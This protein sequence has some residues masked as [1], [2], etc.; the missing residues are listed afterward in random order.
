MENKSSDTKVQK[1]DF[2]NKS[3]VG[4]IFGRLTV[5]DDTQYRTLLSGE[6]KRVAYCKCECG[7]FKNIDL[8][9]LKKGG[10][11]SC[12]CYN[13]D[14]V[15]KR[16]ITHG[17]K[18]TRFY[19]I[20]CD[21]NKRCN[22]AKSMHYK[23]Y[24]GRGI[25]NDFLSFEHFRDTMLATYKDNL[26]LERIDVNGNYSPSNCTWIPFIEQARN[27]RNTVRY[28]GESLITYCERNSLN[29]KLI[30]KRLRRGWSIEDAISKPLKTNKVLFK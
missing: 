16:N 24:G 9:A 7:K 1:R 8:A 25:K 15:M 21:M 29:N 4:E 12:G 22:N 10:T 30:Q 18:D 26:T 23:N 20:Y 2:P 14:V 28:N 5:I 3:Y 17:M 13:Y 19:S 6:R 27:R 11:K